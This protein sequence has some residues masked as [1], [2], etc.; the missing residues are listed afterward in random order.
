MVAMTSEE[1]SEVLLPTIFEEP[2]TL[3]TDLTG[4]MELMPEPTA[5]TEHVPYETRR[6]LWRIFKVADRNANGRLEAEEVRFV[7]A[8]SRGGW[9][10]GWSQRGREC[11]QLSPLDGEARTQC[12]IMSTMSAPHS[13]LHLH[14]GVALRKTKD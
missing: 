7:A 5:E 9:G 10:R 4:I 14:R 6:A 11:R 13:L 8:C 2:P 12:V 3:E 1:R